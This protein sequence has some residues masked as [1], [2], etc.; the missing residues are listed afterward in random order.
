MIKTSA[1][2]ARLSLVW[3]KGQPRRPRAAGYG[4]V[5]LGQYSPNQVFVDVEPERLGDLHRDPATAEARIAL[6]HLN[7]SAYEFG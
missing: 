3:P 7:D 6:L 1:P 5:M 2:L 4:A